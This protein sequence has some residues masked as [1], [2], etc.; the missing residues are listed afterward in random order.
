MRHPAISV[1]IVSILPSTTLAAPTGAV[2][3][4][5][6]TAGQLVSI[7]LASGAATSVRAPLPAPFTTCDSLEYVGSWFYASY[8]G[9]KVVRFGFDCGDEVDLGPSGFP[10]IEAIALRPDGVAHA[11]VSFDNDVGA[12]AVGVFDP[13]TG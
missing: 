3:Y 5:V 9:G 2:L 13:L 12:E 4:G 1:A 7:D 8:G 10:W 11:S 6:T